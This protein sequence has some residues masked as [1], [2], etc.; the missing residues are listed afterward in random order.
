M[1]INVERTEKDTRTAVPS[2]L[3][4]VAHG[5]KDSAGAVGWLIYGRNFTVPSRCTRT[6]L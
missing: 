2:I 5:G 4:Q 6:R 3:R 1:E